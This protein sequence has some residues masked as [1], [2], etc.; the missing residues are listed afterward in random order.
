MVFGFQQEFWV[1][2]LQYHFEENGEI[3]SQIDNNTW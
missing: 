1:I 3:K 2:I